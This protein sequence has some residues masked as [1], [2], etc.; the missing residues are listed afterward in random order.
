MFV[1]LCKL[2]GDLALP[3]AAHPMQEKLSL[4]MQLSFTQ[5]KKGTRG[6]MESEGDGMLKEMVVTT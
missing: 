1:L 5:I 2:E 6:V 4:R 3:T